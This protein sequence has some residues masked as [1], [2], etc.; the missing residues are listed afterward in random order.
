MRSDHERTIG[1]DESIAGVGYGASVL[2]PGFEQVQQARR[3]FTQESPRVGIAIA[4]HLRRGLVDESDAVCR[5]HHEDALA[6]MLD[7]V[8]RKL[9]EIGEIELLPANQGFAFPQ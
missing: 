4:E 5:V 2:A 8:L 9:R 7:D 6:Q 1:C 3:R